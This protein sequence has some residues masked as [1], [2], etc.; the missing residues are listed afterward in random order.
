M[1]NIFSK[2]IGEKS[3]ELFACVKQNCDSEKAIKSKISFL[4]QVLKTYPNIKDM[5]ENGTIKLCDFSRYESK[6]VC[7]SQYEELEQKK[8]E[9]FNKQLSGNTMRSTTDMFICRKCK[10][11]KCSYYELQTRSADEP[12]TK[13][14]KC[15]NC[16]FEW[17]Q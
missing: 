9:T 3:P 5:V 14:I 1:E 10:E 4:L 6:N 12:M 15:C 2:Y 11:R 7:A 13:F 17:R 16:G 8:K